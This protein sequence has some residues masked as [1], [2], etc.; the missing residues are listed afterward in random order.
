MSTAQM[1]G[2]EKVAEELLGSVSAEDPG[3]V[4]RFMDSVSS[5][6]EWSYVLSEEDAQDSLVSSL[7]PCSA[8]AHHFALSPD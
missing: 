7:H 8:S 1:W 5:G 3:V 4:N 2:T 6:H